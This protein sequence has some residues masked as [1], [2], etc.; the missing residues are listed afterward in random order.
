MPKIETAV[1]PQRKGS[2]YPSSF[3]AVS[4]KSHAISD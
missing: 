2:G 1:V 3:D 4:V